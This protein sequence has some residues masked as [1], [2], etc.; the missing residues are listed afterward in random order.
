VLATA[1]MFLQGDL[2]GF[3][4]HAARAAHPGRVLNYVVLDEQGQQLLNTLVPWGQ[5]LPG[6][7]TPPA[8]I[9]LKEPAG[10]VL[11]DHFIGPVSGRPTVAMG[12][13]VRNAQGQ[14]LVLA[15]GLP[16]D[17]LNTLLQRQPL[18]EG[19]LVA[20]LDRQGVIVA[21]SRDA[22]QFTGQAAV[23]A[24]V[25]AARRG[26]DGRL[27][28]VTKDGVAVSTSHVHSARWGWTVA[29]GAPEAQL[30]AERWS[31]MPTVIGGTVLALAL[32]LWT[33]WRLST[34]VLST[35]QGLNAAAQALREGQPMHLPK[36]QLREAEDVAMAMQQAARAMEQVKY[37]AQHDPLTGI[38]NR[39]L[40][41][42]LAKHRIALARRQHQALA[43]LAVDLDGFKAVNDTDGHAAGDRVLQQA[44]N[45]LAATCREADVA[46]RLGGDEFMVLLSSLD[47]ASAERI[48]ERLIDA[49][50]QPYT[51]TAC[52]VSASVGLAMYPEH[53]DT[54]E[55]LMARAD[56]AL[57]AAK[58]AGK[59]RLRRAEPQA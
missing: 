26:Q 42:E 19:W 9:G 10:V 7:G 56:E 23:P 2:A 12:L 30:R 13:P 54:L 33:A 4:G 39:M 25:E 35:V 20:L 8:L 55:T 6:T 28:T 38:A 27:H 21:R 53:G 41:V 48:G 59:H 46:A 1:N 37:L 18:P 57:Y 29:V 31:I 16:T 36:V 40:F 49:L 47:A 51:G 58:A 50:A 43:L 11:T 24:L 3:H 14:P 22:A 15:M 52:R 45:R 44:A 5:P 34:R 17:A 32:G